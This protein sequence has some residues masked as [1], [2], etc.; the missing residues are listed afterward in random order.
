[1]QGY[2]KCVSCWSEIGVKHW[3]GADVPALLLVLVVT[4]D[5]HDGVTSGRKQVRSVGCPDAC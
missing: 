1:M 5:K 3:R 2:W 4:V